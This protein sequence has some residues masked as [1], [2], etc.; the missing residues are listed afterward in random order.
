MFRALPPVVG[1]FLNA[2][3]RRLIP[4]HIRFNGHALTQVEYKTTKAKRCRI[5]QI[6]C[7]SVKQRAKN[8]KRDFFQRRS[9]AAR[10]MGKAVDRAMQATDTV[11]RAQ[12]CR[13]VEVWRIVGGIR[14][15][16]QVPTSAGTSR[17][18][19]LVGLGLSHIG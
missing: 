2:G 6:R 14:K 5:S 9:Y 1:V 18:L 13:W 7:S 15:P 19:R 16:V 17:K 8:M 12:A 11:D 10:R 4:Q 3:T